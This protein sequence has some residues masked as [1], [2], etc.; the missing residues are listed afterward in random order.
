[1]KSL[2]LLLLLMSVLP[3]APVPVKLAWD[4]NPAAEVITEYRLSYGP[5]AE[6]GK[7]EIVPA[8]TPTVT[9]QLEPGVWHFSVLAVNSAGAGPSS[10]EILY[11]L[12]VL[13]A[14]PNNLRVV[15]IETSANLK[16]WTNVA[17]V[18]LDP[19]AKPAEFVRARIV[20]PPP[21]A[22]PAPPPAP[23]PPVIANPKPT[24]QPRS[25]Q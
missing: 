1:M 2:L 5:T 19:T 11:T 24:L 21:P 15:E 8:A 18:K 25:D 7:T 10:A 23:I 4:A 13:P 16:D 20:T 12:L 9:L 6:L 17:S 22:A 3:A 14:P